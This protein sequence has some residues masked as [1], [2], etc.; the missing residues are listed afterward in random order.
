MYANLVNELFNV[1]GPF[2]KIQRLKYLAKQH[3]MKFTVDLPTLFVTGTKKALETV[4][5]DFYYQNNGILIDGF[6]GALKCVAPATLTRP[7]GP[8]FLPDEKEHQDK[9]INDHLKK[10]D[11]D[12]I[13]IYDGTVVTLYPVFSETGNLQCF[14]LATNSTPDFGKRKSITGRTH[15][16]LVA[17]LFRKSGIE[18]AVI[19]TDT[20]DVGLLLPGLDL[21]H[22]YTIG[23]RHHE[24][25]P[26]AFDGE[27]IWNVRSVNLKTGELS[28]QK[29]KHIE[30]EKIVTFDKPMSLQDLRDE[31]APALSDFLEAP[32]TT[33]NYGYI[34]K[35][36]VPGRLPFQ[37]DLF[38]IPS[39]FLTFLQ[40]TIYKYQYVEGT[41][42]LEKTVLRS[43]LDKAVLKDTFLTIFPQ[44]DGE[45]QKFNQVL[46]KITNQFIT[47][48]IHQWL[49]DVK[50]KQILEAIYAEAKPRFYDVPPDE[51][52]DSVIDDRFLD[53]FY[54]L[55]H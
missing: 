14:K 32:S 25:H 7:F 49:D 37:E 38:V 48:Y 46:A 30:D 15:N 45:Y 39:S 47:R 34:L 55:L 10:G 21:D 35:S 11:Y 52:L 16:E 24:A 18:C 9:M 19:T 43:Y 44:F 3:K 20:G 40:D 41:L 31:C 22:C 42:D 1:P 5:S 12:I 8:D 33:V 2:Y 4:P 51:L 28:T 50:Y 27:R 23:Y 36:K 54:K 17:E 26:F 29:I 13:Q 6:N 53:L